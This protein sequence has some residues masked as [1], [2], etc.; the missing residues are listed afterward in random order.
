[1]MGAR[2]KYLFACVL[3]ASWPSLSGAATPLP[4]QLAGTW[5]E[6][7]PFAGGTRQIDLYLEADGS[8]MLFGAR[9]PGPAAAGTDK[10]EPTAFL[11][12]PIEA[13]L[14]GDV[15][16]TRP[17]MTANDR[18]GD[19]A[20]MTL[21]CRVAATG[22]DLRCTDPAGVVI[23]MQRRSGTATADVADRLA[24]VRAQQ[25]PR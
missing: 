18:A 9:T 4:P 8:G 2:M 5:T 10:V 11:A 3:I 15:L 13:T 7:S 1:M 23:A 20:R 24:L 21:T 22:P 14:D 16:T 19:A 12:M 6:R 17:S 25:P